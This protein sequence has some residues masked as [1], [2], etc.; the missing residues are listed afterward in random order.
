MGFAAKSEL[1][2]NFVTASLT[3]STKLNKHGWTLDGDAHIE[4][5]AHDK[6][7]GV[8]AMLKWEW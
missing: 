1:D 6:N 3:G 2:A 5:G 8:S 7:Y 4:K